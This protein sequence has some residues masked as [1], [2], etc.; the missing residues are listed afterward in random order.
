M[1]DLIEDLRQ[2]ENYL[3]SKE[4]ME[5][6]QVTRNTLCHWVRARR[7]VAIRGGNGYRY[8]PR[9][10]AD[11]LSKRETSTASARRVA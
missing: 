8:D 3:T 1:D 5:L 6:L 2:R 4:V 11:W 7:M 9:V 10:M